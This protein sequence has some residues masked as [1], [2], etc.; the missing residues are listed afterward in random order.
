MLQLPGGDKVSR[1][2][3]LKSPLDLKSAGAASLASKLI[4]EDSDGDLS[5]STLLGVLEDTLI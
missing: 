1:T 2:S 5:L 3:L 4:E